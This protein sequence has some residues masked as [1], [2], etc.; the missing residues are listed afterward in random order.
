M[1]FFFSA[2]LPST[3]SV[4]FFFNDT[5][6]TEIYTL[7]LHD[8]LPIFAPSAFPRR[9]S[10][11]RS[12][13]AARVQTGL[14][15]LEAEKF[16]P[17]RGKH[18][19]LITNHTGFDALGRSNIDLLARAAGLQLVALFSPEHGLVGRGNENLASSKDPTTGLSIY[20]LYGDAR[21]P[22][23]EMLQGVDALVFDI[24]DAGEIGRAHV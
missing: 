14:D 16:A 17:L 2:I 8:A 5:A 15:V 7:S 19:G 21:R 11:K 3:I 12:G 18:I 10:S 9:S 13:H 1:F 24:Q 6:T 23:D 22:T 4:F 20:S